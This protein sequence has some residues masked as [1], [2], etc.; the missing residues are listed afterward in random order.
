MRRARER[1]GL[2]RRGCAAQDV[3]GIAGVSD[4]EHQD[5]VVADLLRLHHRR[6][7]VDPAGE[8]HEVI[9]GPAAVVVHVRRPQVAGQCLDRFTEIAHQMG[10]AVVEADPDIH[11]FEFVLDGLHLTRR[12]DRMVGTGTVTYAA[13]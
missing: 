2:A 3:D 7:P 13:G 6:V 12:L 11:A 1:G 5:A 10:V 4:F 9:V 8:G